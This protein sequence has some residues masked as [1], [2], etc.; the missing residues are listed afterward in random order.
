MF[1]YA[2]D[3]IKEGAVP[4]EALGWSWTDAP[5]TFARGRAAMLIAGAVNTTRFVD[6]TPEAIKGDWDFRAQLAWK[7]GDIGVTSIG[8]IVVWSINK[9]ASE[10]EKAAAYLFLDLYRSYQSQ[11][12]EIGFEGNECAIPAMYDMESIKKAVYKPELRRQSVQ[13][14]GGESMPVNGDQMLKYQHEWWSKAATGE[15]SVEEALKNLEQDVA[16]ISP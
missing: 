8:T 13:H 16:A 12:N 9:N 14:T 11:W 6:K 7:E 2:V 5:E 15:V 4:K 10:A 3:L 1:R